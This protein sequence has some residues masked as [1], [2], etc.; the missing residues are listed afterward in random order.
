LVGL[1]IQLFQMEEL[2]DT[3]GD[4]LTLTDG[5]K[6]GITITEDDIADFRL[7]SGRCLIGKLLSGRRVQKD[8]F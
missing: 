6:I 1:C 7:K 8:A 2:I 3:L 5:E 4:A